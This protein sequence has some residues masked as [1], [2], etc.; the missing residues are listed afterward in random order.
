[1]L[2]RVRGRSMVPTLRSGQ[3]LW[4]SS[5]RSRM[6]RRGEIVLARLDRPPAGFYVKRVIGLPGERVELRQG[7]TYLNGVFLSEPYVPSTAS[8]EPKPDVSCRLSAD[9]FFVLGDA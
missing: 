1:M 6:P 9:S 2:I 3:I 7:K 8:L 4:V 5:N